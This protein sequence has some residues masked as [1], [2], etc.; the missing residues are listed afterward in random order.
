MAATMISLA[1]FQLGYEDGLIFDVF[2][3][4]VNTEKRVYGKSPEGDAATSN[5]YHVVYAVVP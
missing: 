1:K 2:S 3:I 4:T 5:Q